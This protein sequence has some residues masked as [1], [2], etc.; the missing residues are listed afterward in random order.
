V[1]S[2]SAWYFVHYEYILD[3]V[4]IGED[5]GTVDYVV[6]VIHVTALFTYKGCVNCGKRNKEILTCGERYS[7]KSGVSL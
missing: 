7:Y 1:F 4:K 3:M 2:Y 6:L 5:V